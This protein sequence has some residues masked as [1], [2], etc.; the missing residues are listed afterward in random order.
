MRLG[1]GCRV[2]YAS[3]VPVADV[4]HWGDPTNLIAIALVVFTAVGSFAVVAQWLRGR[5]ASI[6]RQAAQ[7]D[8]WCERLTDGRLVAR[9]RNDSSQA[10]RDV[11]LRI[12]RPGVPAAS[13]VS[14]VDVSHDVHAQL[15]SVGVV[16]PRRT[17]DFPIDLSHL[18]RLSMPLLVLNFVDAEGVSWM[19]DERHQLKR[20]RDLGLTADKFKGGQLATSVDVYDDWKSEVEAAV[21]V[22]EVTYSSQLFRS[23]VG[24][25]LDFTLLP[26]DVHVDT[27]QSSVLSSAGGKMVVTL[28][29]DEADH[30]VGATLHTVPSVVRAA[31]GFRMLYLDVSDML[32]LTFEPGDLVDDLF[33]RAAHV[34]RLLTPRGAELGEFIFAEDNAP[35]V[36][37]VLDAQRRLHPEFWQSYGGANTDSG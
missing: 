3:A 25:Q 19:R 27:P 12:S 7:V 31:K 29:F 10:V 32:M 13:P 18:S 30:L 34:A 21:D 16:A 2:Q 1:L 22:P 36:M 8:A 35:L 37:R 14:P 15:I 24:N 33:P 17:V 6:R 20:V 23:G 9:V 11:L 26:A 28:R 4:T 5:R